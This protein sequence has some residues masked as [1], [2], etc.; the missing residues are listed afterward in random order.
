MGTTNSVRRGERRQDCH[1]L[2]SVSASVSRP[3]STNRPT[4][5]LRGLLVLLGGLAI[6]L[7]LALGMMELRWAM[8]GSPLVPTLLAASF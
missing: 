2:M 5:V 7:G 8:L 4:P 6:A 3:T 1:L